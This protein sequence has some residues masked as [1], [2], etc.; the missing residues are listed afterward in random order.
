MS[1]TQ[2]T[3]VTPKWHIS[4]V[5]CISKKK[6]NRFFTERVNYDDQLERYVGYYSHRKTNPNFSYLQQEW[7]I[8]SVMWKPAGRRLELSARIVNGSVQGEIFP[9]MKYGLNG[10]EL[11]VVTKVVC[12]SF[13]MLSTKKYPHVNHITHFLNIYRL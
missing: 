10:R 1:S 7:P 5:F 3:L 11:V 12:F 6:K 8:Y 2:F 4:T 13:I 9:N